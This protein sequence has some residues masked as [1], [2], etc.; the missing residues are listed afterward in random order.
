MGPGTR[1]CSDLFEVAGQLFR[2][3]VYP[4][5]LNRDSS[6]YVSLFLT[7][8]GTACPGFLLYELSVLDQS[9]SKPQHITEARTAGDASQG[10]A[11]VLAPHAGVIAGFPRFIKSSFLHKHWQRFLVED[12]LTVR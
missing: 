3:E 6:K 10:P 7:T 9:A 12:T 5:G 11:A 8:P 1:L 4:A 2:L